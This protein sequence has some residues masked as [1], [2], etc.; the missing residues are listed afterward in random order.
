M[1][2]PTGIFRTI[3]SAVCATDLRSYESRMDLTR[4]Y[5]EAFVSYLEGKDIFASFRWITAAL[6]TSF[7][8]EEE[9]MEKRTGGEFKTAQAY[10]A[11]AERQKD[12]WA[13]FQKIFKV[14]LPGDGPEDFP[15]LDVS[16]MPRFPD[17]PMG[18]FS[19]LDSSVLE[20]GLLVVEVIF[21]FY[22]GYVAFLRFDVR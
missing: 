5:R 9:L 6:P 16:D 12:R 7:Q 4:Q 15:Y 18:L 20:L 2:S 8:T 17:R 13:A 1:I 10:K 19:G 11:W 14:K 22:L 3:A 21:L